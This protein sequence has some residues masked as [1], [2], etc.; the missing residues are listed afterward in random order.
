MIKYNHC[1]GWNVKADTLYVLI[2]QVSF[3]LC[4][5]RNL[6]L[7]CGDTAMLHGG[8]ARDKLGRLA[9]S[10]IQ[11]ARASFMNSRGGGESRP[12]GHRTKPIAPVKSRS[13]DRM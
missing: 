1:L 12:T 13:L 10:T 9:R 3:R 8:I 6:I 7:L 11:L 5:T 4:S 2:P